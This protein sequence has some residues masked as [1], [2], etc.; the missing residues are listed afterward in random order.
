MNPARLGISLGKAAA[1]HDQVVDG[2]NRS[3]RTRN[4]LPC[5]TPFGQ[6]FTISFEGSWDQ[7][8]RTPRSGQAGV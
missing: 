5:Q 1:R 7:L 4:D 8:A 2:R 6:S 3:D